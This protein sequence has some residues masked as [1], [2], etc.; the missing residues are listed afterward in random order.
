MSLAAAWNGQASEVTTS[1]AP[2]PALLKMAADFSG[3]PA[4]K[5]RA[6][7]EGGCGKVLVRWTRA[8]L[9]S[10]TTAATTSTPGKSSSSS[11]SSS[12][13]KLQQLAE[14]E[15]GLRVM[16][17]FARAAPDTYG[18]LELEKLCYHLIAGAVGSGSP[19]LVV[20]GLDLMCRLLSA[21]D[22]AGESDEENVAAAAAAA[23]AAGTERLAVADPTR[24]RFPAP[25]ADCSADLARLV[26]G[27]LLNGVQ[28]LGLA[29]G[30]K[31]DPLPPAS[32][33]RLR[34]PDISRRLGSPL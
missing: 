22:P 20:S 9:Q 32:K 27:C 25:P 2:V 19:V 29:A 34:P 15:A 30:S 21:S 16:C 1:Q 18:T 26:S 17:C 3:L 33:V 7:V 14:V 8:G 28:A 31:K 11:S 13:T 23:A 4:S 12:S 6:V 24:S 5:Q 10:A